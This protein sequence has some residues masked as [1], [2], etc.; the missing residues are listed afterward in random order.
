MASYH[1]DIARKTAYASVTNMYGSMK[2]L[3]S[4]E[5]ENILIITDLYHGKKN[6]SVKIDKKYDDKHIGNVKDF[7]VYSGKWNFYQISSETKY[8]KLGQNS[9][10]LIHSDFDNKDFKYDSSDNNH[11][12]DHGCSMSFFDYDKVK[13]W[14]ID[15]IMKQ[16]ENEDIIHEFGVTVHAEGDNGFHV[17]IFRTEDSFPIAFRFW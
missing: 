12:F 4:F 1:D 5:I 11:W 13:D 2:F 7:H 6:P 3:G 8:K 16:R 10:L 14:S 15:D 17:G 9:W